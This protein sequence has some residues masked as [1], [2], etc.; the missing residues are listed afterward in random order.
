M[1]RWFLPFIPLFCFFA[2]G[3]SEELARQIVHILS[4]VAMDYGAAVEGSRASG[5]SIR[6]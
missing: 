5:N 1:R 4:Y 2:H 3:Q 6:S